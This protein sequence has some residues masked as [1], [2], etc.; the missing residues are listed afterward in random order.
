MH[1]CR[2][3]LLIAV[4]A[5]VLA[6][7][8]GAPAVGTAPS[9]PTAGTA[10]TAIAPT[11]RTAPTAATAPTAQ[12]SAVTDHPNDATQ[13][14]LRLALFVFGGPNVDLFVNGTIAVNGGMAQANLHA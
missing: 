10:P 3:I 5:V 7:C 4:A 13:G 14:R 6:A 1:I 12:P 11:A 2:L 9:A 8:G